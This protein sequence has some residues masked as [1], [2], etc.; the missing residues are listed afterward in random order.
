MANLRLQMRGL[1]LLAA[2][3]TAFSLPGR[4][5]QAIRQPVS[6][7]PE[8][9]P[10]PS[11]NPRS[12]RGHAAKC[13]ARRRYPSL[14]PKHINRRNNRTGDLVARW[15][16]DKSDPR[17]MSRSAPAGHRWEFGRLVPRDLPPLRK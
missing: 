4:V 6:A 16:S 13:E 10:V 1:A 17:N 5:L 9:S 14:H 7:R 15:P 11:G 8:A 3:G 2:L 12:G